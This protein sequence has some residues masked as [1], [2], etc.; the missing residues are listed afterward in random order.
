MLQWYEQNPLWETYKDYTTKAVTTTP[1]AEK[2]SP[3]KSHKL[4]V[5]RK[6]FNISIEIR[7]KKKIKIQKDE[8]TK[9]EEKTFQD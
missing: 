2:M 3:A 8:S 7:Q 5:H 6:D 1:N 9:F 4:E